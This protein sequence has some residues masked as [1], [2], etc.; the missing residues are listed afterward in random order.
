MIFAGY[1]KPTRQSLL[2]RTSKLQMF[3]IFRTKWFRSAPV[4]ASL[5]LTSTAV[6]LIGVNHVAP[7]YLFMPVS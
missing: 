2:T 1:K 3:K 5:W 7:D 6:I 4:V